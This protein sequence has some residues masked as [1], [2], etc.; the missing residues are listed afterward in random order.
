MNDA[1]QP[2]MFIHSYCWAG[3]TLFYSFWELEAELLNSWLCSSLLE[4]SA[5]LCSLRWERLHKSWELELRDRTRF[6]QP[7]SLP[8]NILSMFIRTRR[9]EIVIFNTPTH[10]CL[11]MI[12]RALGSCY[13]SRNNAMRH[14]TRQDSN[15]FEFCC[16]VATHQVGLCVWCCA[17]RVLL[18]L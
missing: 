3:A 11:N 16:C 5:E 13:I 4:L 8:K 9:S 15:E 1:L 12:L 6:C 7:A 14:T 2:R 17:L 18:N 10:F